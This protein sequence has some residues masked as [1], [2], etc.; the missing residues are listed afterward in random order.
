MPGRLALVGQTATGKSEVAH[1]VARRLGDVEIVTVDSMQVY[2]GMDI[3]TAKPPPTVQSEVAYHL[4]DLVDPSEEYSLREYQRAATQAIAGI[5]T[6]GNRPLLVGGTGLYVRAVVDEL[7]IPGQYPDQRAALEATDDV[8]ALY[9]QLVELDPVAAARMEPT[10]RRRIVR[11][12]EVCLGSGRTFSSYGEGLDAYQ[13]TAWDVVGL[14]V[15]VPVINERIE[16]RYRQQ[17]DEG[18]LD[19]VAALVAKGD[20]S[21]TASQAL[22]YKQFAEHL[23]GATSLEEAFNAAVAATR[24]FGRRQRSWFGRDPR[25]DWL[26]VTEADGQQAAVDEVVKRWS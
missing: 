17:L 10:N 7:E 23:R 15:E 18:F 11:A 2:R 24:R 12:L 5:E 14:R 20:L 19:E 6:R 22:G 1:L 9:G 21:R 3:G 13:P 25:I 26:D 16:A 4:I 8:A